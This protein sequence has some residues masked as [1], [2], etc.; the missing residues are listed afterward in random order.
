[1]ANNF[2]SAGKMH[3]IH[4]PIAVSNA[5]DGKLNAAFNG[6]GYAYAME[7]MNID[8]VVLSFAMSAGV[9]AAGSGSTKIGVYANNVAIH[10]AT[11]EVGY[12]SAAPYAVLDR[13]SLTT[14]ALAEGDVIRVDLLAVPG[15][16]A[17]SY[18]QSAQVVFIGQSIG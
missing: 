14:K 1:M 13:A 4:V 11:F 12:A 10:S 15:G 18:A 3:R 2:D 9:N 5:T 7:S 17:T 16:A 8:K 6:V